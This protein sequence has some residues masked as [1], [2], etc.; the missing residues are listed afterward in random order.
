MTRALWIVLVLAVGCGGS[1]AP[2]ATS[3]APVVTPDAAAPVPETCE[4]TRA[5]PPAFDCTGT[6]GCDTPWTCQPQRPCTRDAVEYCTCDGRT[7][8]GSSRCPPE[9]FKHKGA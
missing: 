2:G 7:V 3:E 9:P 8:I 4:S 6:E 5:C 1:K